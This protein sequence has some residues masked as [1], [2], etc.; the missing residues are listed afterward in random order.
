M[1]VHVQGIAAQHKVHDEFCFSSR[2][3]SM[4][5]WVF[6]FFQV[7]E[8]SFFFLPGCWVEFFFSS[9]LL[10]WVCFFPGR[11]A[12]EFFFY[13]FCA[14]PPP[15]LYWVFPNRFIGNI[16]MDL[17]WNFCGILAHCIIDNQNIMN[18]ASSL[19]T[20]LFFF[21]LRMCCSFQ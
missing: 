15:V 13:H 5:S 8:L 4:L 10:S 12:V 2:L 1:Y 17:L 16:Y 21:F 9:G 7:V 20:L 6:F 3:L 14:G 18:I 11:V 19:F